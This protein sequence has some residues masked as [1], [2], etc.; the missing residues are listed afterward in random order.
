MS[1]HRRNNSNNS[2]K[3]ILWRDTTPRS[4]ITGDCVQITVREAE[5]R[6]SVN[7][8]AKKNLDEYWNL[9]DQ[10]TEANTGFIY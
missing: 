8:Q 9:T 1:D 3:K 2:D 7:P 5:V 6:F 4:T 10:K